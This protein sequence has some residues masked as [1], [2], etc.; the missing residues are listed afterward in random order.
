MLWGE[1]PAKGREGGDRGGPKS[2]LKDAPFLK[3]RV[4]TRRVITTE[5][6][7]APALSGL[8]QEF[9]PESVTIA[10]EARKT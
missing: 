10:L 3:K 1:R 9:D 6:A 5:T 2:R 4:C 8:C 7:A